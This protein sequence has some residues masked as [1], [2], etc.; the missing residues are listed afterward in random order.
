MT[1]KPQTPTRPSQVRKCRP[2][3]HVLCYFHFQVSKAFG[4]ILVCEFVASQDT[5]SLLANG[6]GSV[7]LTDD[8]SNFT[9]T[10]GSSHTLTLAHH[11]KVATIV[12]RSG[13]LTVLVI[14]VLNHRH[15][16]G[17]CQLSIADHLR[18]RGGDGSSAGE[19]RVEVCARVLGPRLD[20]GVGFAALLLA[21]GH[22]LIV[23]EVALKSDG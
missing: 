6:N 8:A 16:I 21:S 13:G 12:T 7:A 5:F 18:L 17:R 2:K 23:C 1:N 4:R 22:V 11:I 19:R 20:A 9:P 15:R 10:R 14:K 3:R